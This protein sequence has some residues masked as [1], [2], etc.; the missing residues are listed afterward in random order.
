MTF[1]EAKQEIAEKHGRR[2][3][4][5]LTWDSDRGG[6]DENEMYTEAADL[7]AKSVANE[8]VNLD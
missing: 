7:F 2:D 8:S 5:H 3:W 1:E 4:S 6:F